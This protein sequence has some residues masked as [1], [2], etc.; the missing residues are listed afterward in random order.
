MLC[1]RIDILSDRLKHWY[2]D[3]S[4]PMAPQFFWLKDLAGFILGSML[5]YRTSSCTRMINFL[6]NTESY[7]NTKKISELSAVN[8]FHDAFA[9]AKILGCLCELRQLRR[10]N[11]DPD[12]AF[13]LTGDLNFAMHNLSG[14][15][16]PQLESL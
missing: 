5:Y 10:Y 13:V 4:F 15:I 16:S 3:G 14:T 9:E 1:Q 7:W 2:V 6:K 12:F 8:A 11:K